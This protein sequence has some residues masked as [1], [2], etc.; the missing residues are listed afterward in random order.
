[1]SRVAAIV[2]ARKEAEK[3]LDEATELKQK[4][5]VGSQVYDGYIS[6]LLEQMGRGFLI[7]TLGSYQQ[8]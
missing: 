8:D 5:K 4:Y 6:R 3:E 1:M 2:K 7:G